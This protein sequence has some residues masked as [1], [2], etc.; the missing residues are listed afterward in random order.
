MTATAVPTVKKEITPAQVDELKRQMQADAGHGVSTK[1]E[2]VIVPQIHVLQ[3]LSPEVLDGPATVSGARP[4]D[5]LMGVEIVPGRTGFWF[6]LCAVTQ[7][8]LEFKPIDS[9]GGFVASYPFT[10][11]GE[12]PLGAK[13]YEKMRLRFESGNECIHYRQFCGVAWRNGGGLEYVIPFKSTGHTVAKTWMMEAGRANRFPDGRAP[14]LYGHIWKLTTSQ[15]KNASG[16]WYVVDVSA[17]LILTDPDA[18]KVVGDPTHA[19]LMGRALANAFEVGEK[20]A[21]VDRVVDA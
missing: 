8:W 20:V 11:E 9:G 3:P 7:L 1:V 15:R 13:R 21:E 14:P 16:Q 17:P 10:S 12:P 2:D 18:A 5:F 19:Y 6:Q 4:G